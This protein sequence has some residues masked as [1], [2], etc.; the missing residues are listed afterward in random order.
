MKKLI[1]LF[2]LFILPLSTSSQQRINRNV[3]GLTLG[4]YYRVEKVDDII[5]DKYLCPPRVYNEGSSTFIMAVG[6]IPFAGEKWEC[7]NVTQESS[8][9]IS[10]IAF[11]KSF[12]NTDEV[13]SFCT[14]VAGMLITKYGPPS[15]HGEGDLVLEW[16]WKDTRATELHLQAIGKKDSDKP[17]ITVWLSYCDEKLMQKI[18]SDT[19]NEL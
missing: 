2:L 7:L 9:R 16:I 8:G 4:R 14:K 1:T 11:G 6:S 10:E 19:M 17:D 18:Q 13:V 15:E 12:K 5:F 3:A